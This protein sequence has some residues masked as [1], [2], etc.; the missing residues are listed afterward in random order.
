[1]AVMRAVPDVHVAC[2]EGRIVP[3]GLRELTHI[4][5]TSQWHALAQVVIF[6]GAHEREA[7]L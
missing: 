3:R 2:G 5:G 1:M 6:S 4:G 7:I